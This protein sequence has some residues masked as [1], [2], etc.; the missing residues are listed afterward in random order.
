MFAIG[1]S[2]SP[3][4]VVCSL[5]GNEDPW[6][7]PASRHVERAWIHG[8]ERSLYEFA[9]AAAAAGHDV[10]LRGEVVRAALDPMA[11]AAAADVRT[12]LPPRRPE[13]GEVV[14]VPE[15]WT[16]P[17]QFARIALSPA[18]AMILVLGPPGLVGWDF[19]SEDWVPPDILTVETSAI[20]TPG[21]YRGMC[22]LGFELI[23]NALS[24]AELA[25]AAGVGCTYIGRG[26][27]T[28]YP[29]GVEK[30][31]DVALVESNRWAQIADGVISRLSTDSVQRIGTVDNAEMMGLLGSAR[32]LPWPA[33]IDTV[34]RFMNEARAMGTVPV[35]LDT[36]FLRGVN[37]GTGAIL[38]P[39]IEE[40]VSE[41]DALLAAPDRLAVLSD[42][43][44]DAARELIDWERYV[45]VVAEV[46]SAPAPER[47]AS[48]AV[49]DAV[50]SLARREVLRS[51]DVA[52]LVAGLE[53]QLDDLRSTRTFRYS[54][55]FRI[56][57]EWLRR[58][59][60]MNRE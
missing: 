18:R 24:L 3:R 32:V 37:E 29:L 21:S 44:A 17:L 27:P 28:D 6:L 10:E 53:R 33:P 56:P 45:K 43:A 19:I 42:R 5:G 9:V 22:A 25:S 60:G 2:M 4:V 16:E 23:T 46:L 57:Y 59:R 20:A 35:V 11:A 55:P 8:G 15:G 48:A 26:V 12:G 54:A 39:S 13:P 49:G 36:P 58:R 34:S 40:M 52:A 7:L 14:V 41:V 50:A 47:R 1:S 51:P 38:V 31:H 30:T